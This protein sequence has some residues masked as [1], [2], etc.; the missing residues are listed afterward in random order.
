MGRAL[1]RSH[2][3]QYLQR[4]PPPRSSGRGWGPKAQGKASNSS[5]LFP[6]PGEEGIL[7]THPPSL[8]VHL[9]LETHWAQPALSPLLWFAWGDTM[10][11]F[12]ASSLGPAGKACSQWERNGFGRREGPWSLG[13]G[14]W[15]CLSSLFSPHPAPD[16]APGATFPLLAAPQSAQAWVSVKGLLGMG[17]DKGPDQS[18]SVSYGWC[19]ITEY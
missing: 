16:L 5:R 18:R 12:G 13:A 4:P 14:Q 17:E 15:P 10:G 8:H 11:A 2:T 6:F 19:W 9:K 1:P 3:L 7:P